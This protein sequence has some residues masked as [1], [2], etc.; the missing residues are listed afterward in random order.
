MRFKQEYINELD[1]NYEE[2][3]FKIDYFSN[4]HLYPLFLDEYKH[5]H[6]F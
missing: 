6:R 4:D 3:R 2:K 5:I 1:L